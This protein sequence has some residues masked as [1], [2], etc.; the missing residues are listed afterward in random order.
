[1]QVEHPKIGSKTQF[2]GVQMTTFRYFSNRR[3]MTA[4]RQ[5]L[6]QKLQDLDLKYLEHAIKAS[7]PHG[8]GGEASG[9][10]AAYAVRRYCPEPERSKVLNALAIVRADCSS[11]NAVQFRTDLLAAVQ[12]NDRE[13]VNLLVSKQVYTLGEVVCL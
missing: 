3:E 1:V 4:P 2:S 8:K 13:T 7:Y 10:I 12:N 6:L 9:S 5:Y 11:E